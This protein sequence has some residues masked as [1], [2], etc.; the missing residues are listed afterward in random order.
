MH[1]L[2]EREWLIH[3]RLKY[4]QCIRVKIINSHKFY[5]TLYERMHSKSFFRQS[6]QRVA[7]DLYAKLWMNKWL[8]P[9]SLFL[10]SI[11]LAFY[12]NVE[13]N[14]LNH[15]CTILIA[16]LRW[17]IHLND[18]IKEIPF[19]VRRQNLRAS[20]HL[21]LHFVQKLIIFFAFRADL[22]KIT[23]FKQC[24]PLEAF[25]ITLL[26]LDRMICASEFCIS[27]KGSW[28]FLGFAEDLRFEVMA[29]NVFID[30]RTNRYIF[31]SQVIIFVYT[32]SMKLFFLFFSNFLTCKQRNYS[33]SLLLKL[34]TISSSRSSLSQFFL[35]C[36]LCENL[37]K[38]RV[39]C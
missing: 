31:F 4:I 25:F 3:L 7:M 30:P 34:K 29:F 10:F 16:L 39:Q 35:Q 26:N 15:D 17:P 23:A 21:T 12:Q 19:Q 9:N 36:E 8:F 38:L 32:L 11:L 28:D 2:G 27:C 1:F 5:L 18:A 6:K 37:V 20:L 14:Y 24:S 33:W 13:N 22:I